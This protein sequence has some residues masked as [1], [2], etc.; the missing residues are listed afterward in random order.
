VHAVHGVVEA[1]DGGLPVGGYAGRCRGQRAGLPGAVR[2]AADGFGELGHAG[3]GLLQRG[4][5]LLGARGQIAAAG[6]HLAGGGCDGVGALVHFL[7]DRGEV[8]AHRFER[9]HQLA[10]LVGGARIDPGRQVALGHVVRQVQCLAER[11]DNGAGDPHAREDGQHGRGRHD[12]EQ[13]R[14]GAL[15]RGER[16]A[17]G[18]DHAL[19]LIGDQAVEPVEV[20]RLHGRHLGQ[21]EGPR[22]LLVAGHDLRDD[23]VAQRAVALLRF[24]DPLEQVLSGLRDD[25]LL[26]I[27]TQLHA[28]IAQ[29]RQLLQ[30]HPGGLG[31][32]GDPGIAQQ[33]GHGGGADLHV[34]D[35]GRLRI[36]VAGDLPD[37]T[38]GGVEPRDGQRRR[39]Q[40]Q[41]DHEAECHAKPEPDLQAGHEE[42]PGK[43]DACLVRVRRAV[44]ESM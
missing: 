24:Q 38:A 2:V 31:I 6:G 3:G 44:L 13:Q 21:Q 19:R 5:L 32:G 20:G 26:Q 1:A 40:P 39:Q 34:V 42:T 43:C 29:L 9:T 10:G 41:Q 25:P 17:A 4:G 33:R 18:L 23:A 36:E 27:V 8:G 12:G 35:Q 7:H 30:R 15:G 16:A 37:V 14:G 22:R 28:G 11:P